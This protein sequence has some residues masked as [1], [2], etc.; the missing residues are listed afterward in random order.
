MKTLSDGFKT[1]IINDSNRG[2][3]SQ[4]D[5]RSGLKEYVG[6]GAVGGGLLSPP[7]LPRAKSH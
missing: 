4:T 6:G 1:Q 7:H 3:S 5:V 2:L